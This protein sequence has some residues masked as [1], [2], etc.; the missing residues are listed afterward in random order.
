[1][2]VNLAFYENVFFIPILF[3]TLEFTPA[4]YNLYLTPRDQRP[5]PH[6][7]TTHSAN[8]A[9]DPAPRILE[10]L[11]RGCSQAKRPSKVPPLRNS[12]LI[13]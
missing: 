11:L 6:N 2:V 12:D 8:N 9:P 7:N 5:A 1:M 13:F 10:K 4:S 3:F